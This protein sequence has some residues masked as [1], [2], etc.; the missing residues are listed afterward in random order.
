M[1]RL[2]GEKRL[3]AGLLIL[4]MLAGLWFP[5]EKVH[6]E[7]IHTNRDTLPPGPVMEIKEES[8][9]EYEKLY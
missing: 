6:A 3:A 4:C 1:Y 2:K 7:Y 5:G 9:E 8:V